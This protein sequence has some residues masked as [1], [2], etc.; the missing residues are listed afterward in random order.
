MAET[1][2]KVVEKMVFKEEAV[3]EWKSKVLKIPVRKVDDRKLEEAGRI[4]KKHPEPVWIDSEHTR[5]DG[6]WYDAALLWSMHLLRQR[7]PELEYEIQVFRIG[8]ATFVSLPGEPFV[9]GGL[10][11]KMASPACATYIVHGTNQYVGYIPTAEAFKRGGHEVKWSRLVPE[12]LDMIVEAAVDLLKE[13][14]SRQ[15]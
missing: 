1:A 12:A 15:P 9:E 10:R 11:I 4:L 6:K 5:V 13:V 7:E 2:K 3:L 8:N 14:F